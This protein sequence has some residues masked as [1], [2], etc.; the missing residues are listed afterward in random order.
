[1][2]VEQVPEVLSTIISQILVAGEFR[3][4]PMNFILFLAF[5]WVTTGPV[6]AETPEIFSIRS[7]ESTNDKRFEYDRAVIEL[8]L[9]KT[10]ESYGPFLIKM[11]PPMNFPRAVL[12]AKTNRYPN[13]FIKLTY[14]KG[15]GDQDLSYV[16]FP[17]DLGIVGYRVCFASEAIKLKVETASNF[18]EIKKFSHGQG[19]GWSDTAILRANGFQ[20]T[21]VAKY[22]NLFPMVARNRF[23]LFCRGANEIL[24]EYMSHKHIDGLT[25]DTSMA[26]AYP[27]P[28]FFLYA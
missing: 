20:V 3:I 17:V 2:F 21:E 14:Q 19:A 9:E 16:L 4:K 1:V 23:D 7:P 13:L 25:Y 10:R 12:S 5:F 11:A 6:L 15:L 18:I 28:R 8:S 24:D 22:K 26:I 27:L